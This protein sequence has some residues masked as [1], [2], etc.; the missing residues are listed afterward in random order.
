ME[1]NTF[2]G[3]GLKLFGLENVVDIRHTK[4]YAWN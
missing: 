4:A 2:E 1:D 3:D